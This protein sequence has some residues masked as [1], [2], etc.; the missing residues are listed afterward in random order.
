M[1]QPAS[2]TK[3]DPE[4][5]WAL[6]DRAFFAHGGCHILAGVYLTHLPRPGFHAER[7]IPDGP[8]PGNHVYVI[9]GHIT[10]DD[11]GYVERDRLLAWFT[12]QWRA[13]VSG[14]SGKVH[15]VDLDLLDSAALTA[16]KMRGPDQ[17]LYNP[18]PRARAVLAQKRHATAPSFSVLE[19][20][21]G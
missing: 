9:N 17:Y 20:S 1:F 4:R 8:F 18:I 13:Q 15:A 7:I 3:Q 11:R 19:K 2:G 14:W 16:R 6:R 12:A 21:R 10:F 5:R